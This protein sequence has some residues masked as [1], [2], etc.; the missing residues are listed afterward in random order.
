MWVTLSEKVTRQYQCMTFWYTFD[1][2]NGMSLRSIQEHEWNTIQ[3]LHSLS[4]AQENNR[5]L[6]G[7]MP[8]ERRNVKSKVNQFQLEKL[9]TYIIILYCFH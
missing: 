2:C 7:E 5:W 1:Y 3:M 9:H 4:D 6:F 8:L